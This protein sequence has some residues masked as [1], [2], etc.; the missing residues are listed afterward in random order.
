M[1]GLKRFLKILPR[2]IVPLGAL[3]AFLALFRVAT[4]S[5]LGSPLAW[6]I[7]LGL[8]IG[9]VGLQVGLL[10]LRMVRESAVEQGKAQPQVANEKVK[11]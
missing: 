2:I 9:L 1:K 11:R 4:V 7:V 3:A 10:V 8:V 5:Y 6:N